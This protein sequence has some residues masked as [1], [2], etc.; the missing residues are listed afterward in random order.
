MKAGVLVA[1]F[2][3]M[4]TTCFVHAENSVQA[5]PDGL[6]LEGEPLILNGQGT[7][8]KFFLNLYEAGLYL[9]EKS[10]DAA[11]I[12]AA[13][14]PMAIRLHITSSM[15]TSEKME[16]ATL[17]GF[18]KSTGGDTEPIR[19]EI[20]SFVAIFREEIKEGDIYDMV[21]R[22]GADVTVI[23]KNNDQAAVI[24]GPSFKKALFGIWLS[25]DPVQESLKKGLLGEE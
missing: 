13:E 24:S 4:T 10:R 23:L 15:I 12:V 20:D 2:L 22:P 3:L 21:Y 11:A 17:E 14:K 25:S 18:V 1:V 8:T 16:K 5:L 6:D 9:K 7:R 19:D